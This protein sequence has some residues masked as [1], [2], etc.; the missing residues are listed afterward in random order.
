MP[1]SPLAL[2]ISIFQHAEVHYGSK[3]QHNLKALQKKEAE[4]HMYYNNH[5]HSPRQEDLKQIR[6]LNGAEVTLCKR[7]VQKKHELKNSGT[8][9]KL[10][11]QS[12]FHFPAPL[13]YSNFTEMT[14]MGDNKPTAHEKKDDRSWKIDLCDTMEHMS[15]LT[16]FCGSL[17][18]RPRKMLKKCLEFTEICSCFLLWHL[19]YERTFSSFFIHLNKLTPPSRGCRK[20]V[21]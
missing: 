11:T 14:R 17:L 5:F 1:K 20:G 6:T 12:N 10:Y 21:R 15:S 2:Q 18:A 13:L 3:L 4:C 16:K 7:M 9:K 8:P 19:T